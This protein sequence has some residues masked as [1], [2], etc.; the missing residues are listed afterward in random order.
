MHNNHVIDGVNKDLDLIFNRESYLSLTKNFKSRLPKIIVKEHEGVKVVR[1]DKTLIGGTKTRIAEYLFHTITNKTVVYVVP[2]FGLAAV[3]ILELCKLYN[4]NAIF[5][6]PACKEVSDHQAYVIDQKPEL[7]K[8]KRIAAMPNLNRIAKKYADLHGYEFL[9]FGLNHKYVIAGAVRVC[10]DLLEEYDEPEEMWTVVST[11]VLTRGLQIGFENTNMRGV[12]VARNMKAGEL[13]RTKII[14]E[15]LNFH[16]KETSLP[17][18]PT[19]EN[20]DAKA[21][22]YIPKNTKKDIWFWNVAKDVKCPKH[23]RKDLVNSYRSWN[24]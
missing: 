16:T 3:A 18:F 23:F 14:S 1:E 21:W 4:K 8:F 15:P 12:A 22:K 6:M 5:F 24:D 11:G 9:P 19:V 20:Y 2:R 10:Q 13:G 7:V 17:P